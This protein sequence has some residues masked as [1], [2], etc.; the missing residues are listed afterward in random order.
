M[1]TRRFISAAFCAATL[2]CFATPLFADGTL[3]TT[4]TP[5]AL[6]TGVFDAVTIDDG[7]T[8][9]V[10]NFGTTASVSS[11]GVTKLTSTGAVDVAFASGLAGANVLPVLGITRQPDGKYVLCG[12]F[13]T[14]HGVARNSVARLNADGTLDTTFDPGTGPV[15]LTTSSLV[16]FAVLALPD[17]RILV[18]GQFDTWNGVARKGLVC[19]KSNGDL[20]TSFADLDDSVTFFAGGDMVRSLALQPLTTAPYYGI[21][22][23]GLFY[24][25]WSG[26]NHSGVI[27]LNLDGT[28]DTSFAIGNGA[29]QSGKVNTLVTVGT[30]GVQADGKILAGGQ[31]TGFNGVTVHS[32]VRLN[33]NGTS[34]TSYNTN[35][36]GGITGG[37]AN[38]YKVLS[39]PD[40]KGLVSGF[41]TTASGTAMAGFAR[42][43]A[44]GTLDTGF[45]PATSAAT[46]VT[47]VRLAKD[48][49]V[50]ALMY[51]ST[52]TTQQVRRLSTSMSAPGAVQLASASADV[53]EGN[54]LTLT[55]NRVDGTAGSL[56]VI[57]GTT[58]GTATLPFDFATTSGTLS[59]ADGDADPKTF[60]INV[61]LDGTLENDEEFKVTL[62]PVGSTRLGATSAAS[63]TIHNA[64]TA[65]GGQPIVIFREAAQNIAE[66]V[67]TI[68][69]HIDLSAVSASTITV[70]FTITGTATATKDYTIAPASPLTFAPGD[71]SKDIVIT[72]INDSTPEPDETITLTIPNVT[73][74]VLDGTRNTFTVTITDNE[75]KPAFTTHPQHVL[76]YVGQPFAIFSAAATGLPAPTLQ[77]LANGKSVSGL[78]GP[79]IIANNISL[80]SATTFSVKATNKIGTTNYSVTSQTAELDVVDKTE[81]TFVLAAGSASNAVM[82]VPV[83]GKLMTYEWRD[84]MGTPLP[85]SS[86]VLNV[87]TKALTIKSLTTADT[88]DYT[89]RVKSPDAAQFIDVKY[90]LKVV[91]EK[92]VIT[93]AS[94]N[95]GSVLVSEPITPTPIHVST[96]NTATDDR[97]VASFRVDSL[98]P[99]IK[100]DTVTGIL[101]GRCTTAKTYN[102]KVFAKNPR[103]ETTGVP[104]TLVVNA[105]PS[106]VAGA[107]LGF[108]ARDTAV[109]TR[110]GRVDFTVQPT[111]TL[112]GKI[113]IGTGSYPFSGAIDTSTATPTACKATIPVANTTLTFTFDYTT[114]TGLLSNAIITD[115]SHPMTVTGWRNVWNPAPTVKP[116]A[117]YYT[118]A[119]NAPP[120]QTNPVPLGNGYAS[121]TVA[122]TGTLTVSGALADGTG[123]STAGFVSPAGKVLIYQ[124]LYGNKGAIHGLLDITTGMATNYSDN[125]ISGSANWTRDPS[126]LSITN[127]AYVAGFT[128][129][130]ITA[131]GA[132]YEPVPSVGIVLDLL[133]QDNNAKLDFSDGGL[134]ANS[135]D[136]NPDYTFRIKKGGSAT[137][138][139]PNSNA[140]SITIK[141]ATGFFSGSFALTQ[142][143]NNLTV[144]KSE[145][146]AAP[147]A[148]MIVKHAIGNEGCGYFLLPEL[149]TNSVSTTL[150]KKLSG[151]VVL[152][153][154]P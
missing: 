137:Y 3:D 42:Y 110:G 60:T 114:T 27:R 23:G 75:A 122:A 25:T 69:A 107:Y 13:T 141:P 21:V 7:S 95:L 54:T 142:T 134:G 29:H 94:I 37:T 74:A 33:A 63:V 17:G 92:P 98:P 89:C 57:Y 91:T 118:L 148:G 136:P 35:L 80:K 44:D 129:A 104:V 146:R 130:S 16:S 105:L 103:G 113:I 124:M 138:P 70:P 62:V 32:Y 106:N 133:D 66:G 55:V 145:K 143:N 38:A 67:T 59:W 12:P 52:D 45:T 120:A 49:Q 123:F 127:R 51:G 71:S 116:Y 1:I 83:A 14:M 97:A 20:D 28:R 4:F 86:R 79:S 132:H 87:T 109:N 34:D 154:G 58:A 76:A 96:M 144:P 48:G 31:F 39:Q 151:A 85:A 65:G 41:F 126:T 125:V 150:T 6:S 5:P 117:G 78:T 68:T 30:V 72:L 101:S 84:A 82:T 73:G 8:V 119:F 121:F 56:S 99:G 43:N 112:S 90:H 88:G 131:V 100:L 26:S 128:D 22:V 149:S 53:T 46:G 15:H 50:L 9:I 147:F 61:P 47:G 19:L 93:D 81:K 36:G 10:G 153:A 11:A 64:D 111:G 102:F 115:G 108:I 135:N 24:G 77:W 40:G 152:K 140:I 18:G 2:G 139:A